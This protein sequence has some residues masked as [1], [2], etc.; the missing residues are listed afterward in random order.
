M[1]QEDWP[2]TSFG[3]IR[4]MKIIIGGD[5]ATKHRGL[6]SVQ[7]QTAFSCEVT[8]ILQEADYTIINLESPVADSSCIPI[9]KIGP[10][11]KTAKE[12]ITYLKK[13]GVDA[14]TLANNHFY[15]YG[16]KAVA[17]TIR[18]LTDKNIDY[19]GGGNTDEERRRILYKSFG[20]IR[21]AFINYCEHEFSVQNEC[22]SNGLDPI[23]AFYDINQ[24]RK[25]ADIVIII[26]HGGHEGYRFPSPRMQNLYRFLIDAGAN[27]VVNHHQHCFSGFEPYG[28]GYI[29]Y[30]LGNFFF[31]RG[32]SPQS[33]EDRS[34]HEGYLLEINITDKVISNIHPIPYI[35]CADEDIQVKT[36]GSKEEFD[37]FEK[38]IALLNTIISDS[39]KLENEFR[40]Y[41]F[42]KRKNYIVDYVPYTNKYLR[43][44]YKRGFLPSFFSQ[45]RQLK[46]LNDIRCEAHR[47]LLIESL[48]VVK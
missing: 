18:E 38:Q 36:T 1:G 32:Y 42:S 46:A 24:A 17:L 44:L 31:D 25:N 2:V 48:S 47:D 34:W 35:Q 43:A 28:G 8:N 10:C 14:V 40:K 27:L 30:G 11:L 12:S 23:Q 19:V 29:Y 41:A 5:F 22:G 26:T 33:E 7:N 13:C 39:T 20:D 45:K 3:I 9:L 16:K 4:G 21:I 15:D 6:C 37:A